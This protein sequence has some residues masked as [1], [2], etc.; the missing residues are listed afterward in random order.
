MASSMAWAMSRLVSPLALPDWMPTSTSPV[1]RCRPGQASGSTVAIVTSSGHRPRTAPLARRTVAVAAGTISR[2]A[3]QS[4]SLGSPSKGR[5]TNG[6]GA[7]REDWSARSRRGLRDALPMAATLVAAAYARRAGGSQRRARCRDWCGSAH[8]TCG[9]EVGG[10][11]PMR[12]RGAGA[13]VVR[14][15]GRAGRR[16]RSRRP[17]RASPRSRSACSAAVP[18]WCRAANV[19]AA[20]RPRSAS[21][22]RHVSSRSR[23][24]RGR[25]STV[26]CTSSTRRPASRTRS[27]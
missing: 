5:A 14:S 19:D 24:T 13:D 8:S 4:V 12:R 7:G 27:R 25:S 16:R 3:T 10:C 15:R 22:R 9:G 2:I 6:A 17:R 11:I 23:P 1:S 20:V 18:A 21:T 26:A